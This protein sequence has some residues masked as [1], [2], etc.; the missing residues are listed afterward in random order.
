MS[1]PPAVARYFAAVNAEDWATITDVF[2]PDA[3]LVSVGA[4]TR[5][6][7]DEIAA[8]FP[9]VLAALPVHHDEPTRVVVAGT[10]VLVEIAFAGRTTDDRPVAFDAVDVFDL[11]ED[12]TT[13]TRLSTWYDTAAVAK[14]IRAA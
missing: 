6:G 8:H 11:T 1:A 10:T 3:A 9:K 4:P 5:N 2:A 14:Q 12:G 7:R 13:I